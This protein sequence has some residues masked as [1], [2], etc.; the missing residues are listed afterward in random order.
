[1]VGRDL[2]EAAN[3]R[4]DIS[5]AQAL[6]TA[7]NTFRLKYNAYPGDMVNATSLFATCEG[8]TTSVT[9]GNGDG[10]I[11]PSINHLDVLGEPVTAMVELACAQLIPLAPFSAFGHNPSTIAGIGRIA[12]KINGGIMIKGDGNTPVSGGSGRIGSGRNYILLGMANN[13]INGSQVSSLTSDLD[14][15]NSGLKGAYTPVQAFNI[16]VKMDNGNPSN[17]GVRAIHAA[18][19][20][21][22][23]TSPGTMN[24]PAR[25]Q[26]NNI[27][28]LTLTTGLCALRLNAVF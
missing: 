6:G 11:A 1:M 26:N 16:D 5:N 7:V 22:L 17:G 24:D 27:Y 25:C 23:E 21:D 15:V 9:N 14:W 3:L 20:F 28:N 2:M 13:D 10:V 19:S 12:S 18:T 4:R 8:V